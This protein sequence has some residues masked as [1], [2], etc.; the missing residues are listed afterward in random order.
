M[1]KETKEL[2]A[3]IAGS[4]VRILRRWYDKKDRIEVEIYRAMGPLAGG[5]LFILK[6]LLTGVEVHVPQ[7]P[8]DGDPRRDYTYLVM[9]QCEA[10]DYLNECMDRAIHDNEFVTKLKSELT[11]KTGQCQKA[12][13]SLY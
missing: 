3:T 12:L 5:S 11:E 10:T 2:D 8:Q 4:Y 7:Y 6:N 9:T 13:K 1:V